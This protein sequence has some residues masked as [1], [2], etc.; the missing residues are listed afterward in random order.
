MASLCMSGV[1]AKASVSSRPG[2]YA[3]S[4]VVRHLTLPEHILP[5]A[6]RTVRR[7]RRADVVLYIG[8]DGNVQ[9]AFGLQH[10]LSRLG[11]VVHEAVP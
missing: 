4:L 9:N 7:S 6:P 5:S 1:S 8:P 3:G 11:H 2:G 10:D